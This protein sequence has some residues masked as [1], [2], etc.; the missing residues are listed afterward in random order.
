MK[1]KV[2]FVTNKWLNTIDG[3][4]ASQ[5]DNIVYTF[6]KDVK[7]YEYDILCLDESYL[8]YNTHIDNAIVKYCSK[9]PF[10]IVIILRLGISE[11]N[12][13]TE[14]IKYLKS[15]GK[16]ICF[17]WLDTNPWDITYQQQN[18]HLI[19]LNVSW[20]IAS[21]KGQLYNG[22]NNH[23]SL[24][25]P[26]SDIIYYPR[27]QENPVSFIG[28]LRYNKRYEYLSY[29]KDEMPELT[30]C[31]G[32]REA[33]LSM[34]EYGNIIGSSKININFPQHGMGYEQSKGRVFQT[35]ASKSLLLENA[36][37]ST[38]SV[39]RPNIDYVEFDS[40]EDLYDKV[41]YYL[42]NEEERLEIANNGYKTYLEKY[43][44]EIFWKTVMDK[45][46]ET[47]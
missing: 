35:I 30:I 16:Y 47:T 39:L 14:C 34:F 10:D 33:N 41:Q 24:W 18:A 7:E 6:S 12:P 4:T 28:S 25:T 19:D 20:D 2:L 22:V 38:R 23:L 31:G 46:N 3:P 32:Q 13:T 44:S 5:Y 9:V 42:K 11:L 40:K 1:P 15:I 27:I 43:T 29:L 8:I 26:E 36:N 37:A 17:F 45:I 21:F